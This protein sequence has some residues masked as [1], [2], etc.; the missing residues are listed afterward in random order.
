MVLVW[1]LSAT[2]LVSAISL[3]GVF[4]I[5]IKTQ[6]FDKI[7]VLLVGFAAGGLIG[8]AF[9]HLL[10]KAVEIGESASVFF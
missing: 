2:I 10:P 4:T 3:V 5:G 9:L 1:I 7:L 8:S 6:A